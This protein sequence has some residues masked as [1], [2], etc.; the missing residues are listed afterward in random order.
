MKEFDD[1]L[2]HYHY[3]HELVHHAQYADAI[4]HYER[5]I[6][7]DPD[8][9][10]SEVYVFAAWLLATCP[11]ISLRNGQ[12]A[13]KFATKA[14]EDTD[15]EPWPLTALAAAHAQNGDFKDAVDAQKRAIELYREYTH[16]R[17]AYYQKCRDRLSRYESYQTLDYDPE[18]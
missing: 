17:P 3:A 12:R 4:L 14:C 18:P 10:D 8:R 11:D 15:W 1:P 16:L 13:V 2:D 7:M 5:A 9:L 6:S